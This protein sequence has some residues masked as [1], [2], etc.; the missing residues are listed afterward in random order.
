MI[1]SFYSPRILPETNNIRAS[2][3]GVYS[4][5]FEEKGSGVVLNFFSSDNTVLTGATNPKKQPSINFVVCTYTE[6]KQYL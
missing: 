3:T 6:S 1:W 5:Q 4:F 2:I